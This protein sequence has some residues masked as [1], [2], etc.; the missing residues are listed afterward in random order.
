MTTGSLLQTQRE[1]AVGAQA[2]SRG[3]AALIAIV[4]RFSGFG[5]NKEPSEPNHFFDK[6]AESKLSRVDKR[7]RHYGETC[8]F[9]FDLTDLLFQVVSLLYTGTAV[10]GTQ[11]WGCGH[12]GVVRVASSDITRYR[13]R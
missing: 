7:A 1:P 4:C 8:T 10:R 3:R 11:G 9:R 12:V 2:W 5:I 13:Y 6:L